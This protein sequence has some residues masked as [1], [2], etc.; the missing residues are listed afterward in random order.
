MV[1]AQRRDYLTFWTNIV[2]PARH[3]WVIKKRDHQ[4]LAVNMQ[5]RYS[6]YLPS[7]PPPLPAAFFW[8]NKN[9]KR[10]G[11]ATLWEQCIVTGTCTG[12]AGLYLIKSRTF[13]AAE[14][15][16]FYLLQRTQGRSPKKSVTIHHFPCSFERRWSE[17]TIAVFLFVI[18]V[19]HN[20]TS[21]PAPMYMSVEACQ[22]ATKV[23]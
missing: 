4:R 23:T 18:A 3:P 5:A 20:L 2:V 14:H 10:V 16:E 12:A 15:A 7:P 22:T 19:C 1:N 13:R 9:K 21:T 8:Q 11:V 6:E 17:W